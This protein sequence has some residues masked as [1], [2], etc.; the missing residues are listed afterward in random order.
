M[1]KDLIV[2]CLEWKIMTVCDLCTGVRSF[3][4]R[5]HHHLHS[6][7][8]QGGQFGQQLRKNLACEWAMENIRSEW[9]VREPEKVVSLAMFLCMTASSYISRQVICVNGRM[10][11]NRFFPTANVN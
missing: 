11:V 3:W 8:G 1:W 5:E 7:L 10:T 9:P 6:F 4:T 2:M